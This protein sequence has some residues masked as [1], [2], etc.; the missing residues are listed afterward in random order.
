MDRHFKRESLSLVSREN[1]ETTGDDNGEVEFFLSKQSTFAIGK[2][3]EASGE[4]GEE[5]RE[6]EVGD[7]DDD[8]C[9]DD[10][11]GD[12]ANDGGVCATTLKMTT[13]SGHKSS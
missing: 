11:D 10:D 3:S 2:P 4:E 1:R 8:D 7:D 13:N 5:E 12:D 9:D 6:E